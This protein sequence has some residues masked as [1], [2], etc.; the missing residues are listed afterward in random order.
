MAKKKDV[1]QQVAEEVDAET[2]APD[3]LTPE[4]LALAYARVFTGE[5]GAIVLADLR[6]KFHGTTVRI[7][8]AGIDP[9]EVIFREGQRHVYLSLCEAQ[10][11][12][13]QITHAE[14]N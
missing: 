11:P 1:L 4:R 12:P 8:P 13:V 7:R 3:A 14:E 9:Y 2:L 10:E 6:Q 5:D